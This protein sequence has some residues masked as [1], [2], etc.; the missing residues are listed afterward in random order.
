MGGFAVY[1]I[2]S[3]KKKTGNPRP[4]VPVLWTARRLEPLSASVPGDAVVTLWLCQTVCY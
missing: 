2:L 1:P 4:T 3:Y